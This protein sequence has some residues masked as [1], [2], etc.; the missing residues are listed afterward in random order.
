MR[1]HH[2][3]TEA[4]R[5]ARGWNGAKRLTVEEP[6]DLRDGESDAECDS[7]RHQRAEDGPLHTLRF[8][9]HGVV[10]VGQGLCNNE[11]S[12]RLTAVRMGLA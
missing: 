5:K 2:G 11:K 8:L 10:V 9:P 7:K 1:I 12:I 3:Y 6:N 4:L